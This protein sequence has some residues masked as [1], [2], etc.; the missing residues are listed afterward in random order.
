MICR[1]QRLADPRR[2]WIAVTALRRPGRVLG[3]PKRRFRPKVRTKVTVHLGSGKS[4]Y[5]HA[6]PAQC[7]R[8]RSRT[9]E[10]VADVVGARIP[11]RFLI[12]GKKI[13]LDAR[14]SFGTK[15]AIHSSSSDL[16]R[17]RCVHRAEDRALGATRRGPIRPRSR[18]SNGFDYLFQNG[19]S[20]LMT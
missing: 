20:G 16:V 4:I 6:L 8:C 2:L 18:T 3:R 14:W 9:T 13:G 12:N 19:P 10:R 1:I 17:A 15:V 7:R 5:A 11:R